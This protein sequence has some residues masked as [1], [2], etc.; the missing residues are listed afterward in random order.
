MGDQS[1]YTIEYRVIA[2]VWYYESDKSVASIRAMKTKLRERFDSEPPDTRYIKVWA[3]KLFQT[4]S[5]IDKPHPG[6]PNERG[7]TLIAVEQSV[8]ENPTTSLRYISL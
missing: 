4:G 6:R 2:S 1:C 8:T 5:I 7:D 3:E